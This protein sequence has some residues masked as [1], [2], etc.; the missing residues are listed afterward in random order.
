[1]RLDLRR[2]DLAEK[3]TPAV[4]RCDPQSM[5]ARALR[6][7]IPVRFRILEGGE[8]ID[9]GIAV[10]GLSHAQDFRLL[11]RIGNMTAKAQ[12]SAAR[13]RNR[14]R[15]KAHAVL[16]QSLIRLSRPVPFQ[17]REF[18]MVKPSPFAVAEHMRKAIDALF[19]GSEQFF[20]GKFRRTVKVEY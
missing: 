14:P 12:I 11:E 10:E 9:A 13:R 4:I 8:K 16:D 5:A 18:G 3:I 2:H 19:T 20:G 1:M 15:K 6:E 7:P 17:H